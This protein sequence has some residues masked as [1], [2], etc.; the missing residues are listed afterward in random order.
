MAINPNMFGIL[1]EHM[2]MYNVYGKLAV[3]MKVEVLGM[4][5]ADNGE[6]LLQPSEFTGSN[7]HSVVFSFSKRASNS[8]LFLDTLRDHTVA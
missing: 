7:I 4:R 6:E 2:I 5:D 3:T 8:S 1:M